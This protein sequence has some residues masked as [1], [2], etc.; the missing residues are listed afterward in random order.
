MNLTPHKH[1]FHASGLAAE[2]F[3]CVPQLVLPSGLCL[4]ALDQSAP[5]APTK[6]STA[7]LCRDPKR[8]TWNGCMLPCLARPVCKLLWSNTAM[9]PAGLEPAIPGPVGRCLIHWATGPVR[10]PPASALQSSLPRRDGREHG[11][12]QREPKWTHWDLN[13]GPSACEADVIPLH[14]VPD[15]KM[16][17][18]TSSPCSSLVAQ[19]CAIDVRK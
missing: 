11:E 14:H 7:V 17:L 1:F 10:I 16:S 2:L 8:H 15:A 13:P 9:T 12:P 4:E 3:F 18:Q 5:S 19:R 6:P